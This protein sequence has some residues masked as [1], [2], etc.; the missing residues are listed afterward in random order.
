MTIA[1]LDMQS[2]DVL[3][4]DTIAVFYNLP[5][6]KKACGGFVVWNN[7]RVALTIWG[8]DQTTK[9]KDGFS[10]Q[11]EIIFCHIKNGSIQTILDAKF[12]AGNNLWSPNGIAVV[13]KL[14][15][16]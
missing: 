2:S 4:G 1:I 9:E 16:E 10:F 8:N 6:E 13:E 11:E 5:N 3:L 15:I 14:Y 7:N 12:M